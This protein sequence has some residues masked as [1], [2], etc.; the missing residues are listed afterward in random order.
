MGQG[1][2]WARGA[3]GP[4]WPMCQWGLDHTLV[5]KKLAKRVLSEL[6]VMVFVWV[7]IFAY[8]QKPTKIMTYQQQKKME[9]RDGKEKCIVQ[10]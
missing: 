1:R 7:A 3:Y 6:Y 4:G 10:E 5:V 2:L 9:K 8:Q